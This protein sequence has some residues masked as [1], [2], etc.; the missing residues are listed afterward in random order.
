MLRQMQES[1]VNAHNQWYTKIQSSDWSKWCTLW[2]NVNSRLLSDI[3]SFQMVQQ[4]SYW[5]INCVTI[6]LDNL[7]LTFWKIHSC[8]NVLE[9]SSLISST[10]DSLLE[11]ISELTETLNGNTSGCIMKTTKKEQEA[12][13]IK[14][15]IVLA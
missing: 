7:Q 15:N 3:T 5:Y 11:S 1:I 14:I 8:G 10:L 13:Y 2:C 6:I 9:T 12:N 4:R